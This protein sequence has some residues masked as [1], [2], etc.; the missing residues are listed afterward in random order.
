MQ[1]FRGS[2]V[3]QTVKGETYLVRSYYDQRG[4]RRQKSEGKRTPETKKMKTDWE[5][6]RVATKERYE[7]IDTVMARQAAIAARRKSLRN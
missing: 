5:Q 4:I 7:A 1:N 2:L 6:A 3:W